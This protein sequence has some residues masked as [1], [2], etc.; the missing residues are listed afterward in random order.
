MPPDPSLWAVIL[1]GGAGSRFWPV[2]TPSRPKQ[3]LPLAGPDP[4]ITATI[5]RILPLVPLDRIRILAGQPLVKPIRRVVPQ[6][7]DGHFLIEPRVRGTA[8]ILAWAA[9]E[10]ARQD[11]DGVMLSLHSD[12]A[13]QPAAAFRDL[14]SDAAVIARREKL[15]LTIGARPDRPETGYG[16]IRPGE[17]LEGGAQRVAQFIEK[18][19]RA[20]AE[21]YIGDG[22]LWNTG[23]FVF[24]VG[25]FLDQLREHTPEL[26][27]LLPLLDA[28]DVHS[29]FEQVPNLT[30]DVGLMERTDRVGVMGATFEWDDVGSWDAVLRT[31][32]PDADGNVLH[33]D[34]YAVDTSGS[35]VWSED[36]SVVVF[37]AEDMVV[38]RTKGVTLVSPRSR[39]GDLKKLIEQLPDHLVRG[40]DG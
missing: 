34:A 10:I 30:I 39:V 17:T 13:I 5:E 26:G 25:V 40:D 7:D 20:T 37:G 4:L 27:A 11:P 31:R 32:T 8:A 19:D 35:V 14:L 38:V 1:A 29:F 15:L 6:L 24:P 23:I 28:G 36:G 12:H 21:R 33:G 3:L 22:Y 16:Y 2:S 18:P 9:H